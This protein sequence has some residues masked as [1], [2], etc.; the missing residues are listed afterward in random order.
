MNVQSAQNAKNTWLS[1]WRLSTN[2][3]S[4][5][6]RLLYKVVDYEKLNN[7]YLLDAS[8]TDR[9]SPSRFTTFADVVVSED[10]SCH[11]VVWTFQAYRVGVSP[12]T[13][14]KHL[15]MP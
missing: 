1:G 14:K 8:A 11:L 2:V 10:G 7:C 5:A 4:K 15:V 12:H 13:F 6:A 9:C 3:L